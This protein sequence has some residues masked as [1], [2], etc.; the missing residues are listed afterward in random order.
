MPRESYEITA[1][2]LLPSDKWGA[3][4]KQQR[5]D[6][7]VLKKCRRVAV[8]PHVTLYFECWDTM[9]YQVQEM[10][11]IEKGGAAQLVDELTAYNPLIPQGQELVATFMIEIPD[12]ARRKVVLAK[13]GGIETKIS[14][15]LDGQSISAIPDLDVDR[16]SASGKTSAVHFLHFPFSAGQ[17]SSFTTGAEVQ[18][19]I[20]HPNY[21]HIAILPRVV[22]DALASDFL[23]A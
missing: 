15:V 3:Q 16:T 9:W 18:V 13:L 5:A 17:I 14:M 19:R 8:G 11:W 21:G 10:L 7:S 6:M 23:V 2:D 12:E 4:R 1:A 20:D 22:Q